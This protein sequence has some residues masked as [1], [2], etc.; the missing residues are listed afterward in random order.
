MRSIFS[1]RPAPAAAAVR[2]PY[3][4]EL[5]LIS[6]LLEE[7]PRAARLVHQDLTHHG[8]IDASRGRSGMSADQVLRAAI[9]RQIEGITYEDLAFRL[10]DSA[11]CR[12]FCRFES[13]EAVPSR[14]TLH[15]NIKALSVSTLQ[16]VHRLVV[17]C[18]QGKGIEDGEAIRV[19]CSTVKAPIHAPTD[20]TLLWDTVRVLVRLMKQAST[21]SDAR[22]T[23]RQR[24]SKRRAMAIQ[25]AS[26]A[27]ARRSLYRELLRATEQ[28]SA[29][30][31]RV[32]ASLEQ[33]RR[34][35]EPIAPAVALAQRIRHHVRLGRR[36]VDQTRRRVELDEV[37]PP[38]E[39]V[40]SIFEPHTDIIVKDRR[41][42]LYGHKV[43]FSFGASGLV[44][45][46]RILDG[47]PADAT[48]AVDAAKQD[49]K[50]Y[51]KPPVSICFDGAFTSKRNLAD[52]KALGIE[53]VVFSKRR[54]IAIEDMTDS[55][56]KYRELRNFRAGA[57][58]NISFLKRAVGL[59]RCLW[60]SLP[61]FHSYVWLGVIAANLLTI[62]RLLTA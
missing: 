25:H 44:T 45:G 2:H 39:K 32:A 46:M 5:E 1:D 11:T 48:L 52:I 36:V 40:V 13:A 10:E 56:R 23:N 22:W 6:R 62:A 42:T 49:K 31:E 12:S 58:A 19:D 9:L 30:A 16:M 15:R 18:A 17:R 34:D 55:A 14:S 47:N 24:Q 43:R 37:V 3:A 60:H 51:G 27:G 29:D 61:S 28:T 33:A 41:E 59:A 7:Q 53:N 21:W 57:E 4:R 8:L 50:L 35:E 26:S 20:S 54:G 38:G